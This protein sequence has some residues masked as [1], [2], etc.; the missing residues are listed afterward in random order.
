MAYGV[1]M[2][3]ATIGTGAVRAAAGRAGLAALLAAAIAAVAA[4]PH[5]PEHREGETALALHGHGV[6]R[7]KG[8]IR[9]YD[10][11]LY[12]ADPAHSARVLEDVPRRLEIQYLRSLDRDVFLEAA[13]RALAVTATPEERAGIRDRLERLNRLYR[14][15][16]KGDRYALTYLPGVGTRLDLNGEA[17]GT[18]EGA[19]FA[20]LYFGIWLHPQAPSAELRRHLLGG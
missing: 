19:D 18:I 8:L 2:N 3:E 12:L 9:V 14:S 5:A 11:A 7:Y 13:D 10:A 1:A 4:I 16:R 17:L 6:L 15:V 20:R